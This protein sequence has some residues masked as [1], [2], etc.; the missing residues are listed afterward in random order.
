[1]YRPGA[2]AQLP[3]RLEAQQWGVPPMPVPVRIVTVIKPLCSS[4][5]PFPG[6]LADLHGGIKSGLRTFGLHL[7]VDAGCC[8]GALADLHQVRGVGGEEWCGQRKSCVPLCHLFSQG[9]KEVMGDFAPSRVFQ[10]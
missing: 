9:P 7:L 3:A 6:A 5:T 10:C 2:A 1:M 4:S 8:S